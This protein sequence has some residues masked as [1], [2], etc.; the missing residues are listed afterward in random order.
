MVRC[1]DYSCYGWMDGSVS[2]LVRLFFAGHRLVFRGLHIEFRVKL[3]FR[4]GLGVNFTYGS[5]NGKCIAR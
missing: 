2:S 3:Y 4:S 5:S 1:G